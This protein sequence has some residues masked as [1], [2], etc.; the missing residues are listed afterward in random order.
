[1]V[2]RY[3]FA[4]RIGARLNQQVRDAKDTEAYHCIHT[5]QIQ[6]YKSTRGDVMHKLF[7]HV[8]Q[9]KHRSMQR[10]WLARD[11]EVP[12]QDSERG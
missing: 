12:W 9:N 7:S 3:V 1:M 8:T 6:E 4:K 11:H 5:N 2:T 10:F